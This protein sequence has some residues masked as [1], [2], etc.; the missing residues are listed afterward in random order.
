MCFRYFGKYIDEANEW[1]VRAKISK[2]KAASR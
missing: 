1:Y 2:K